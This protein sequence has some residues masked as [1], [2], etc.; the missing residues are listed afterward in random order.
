MVRAE[1]SLHLS[2]WWPGC[3]TVSR[4]SPPPAAAPGSSPVAGTSRENLPCPETL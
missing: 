1:Q 2:C 3:G 4:P